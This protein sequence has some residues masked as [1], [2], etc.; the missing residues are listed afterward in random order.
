[1]SKLSKESHSSMKLAI[2]ILVLF[3]TSLNCYSQRDNYWDDGLH[4][5]TLDSAHL[6]FTASIQAAETPIGQ[7]IK[8]NLYISNDTTPRIL[9][10]EM[11]VT[12]RIYEARTII[13]GVNASMYAGGVDIEPLALSSNEFENLINRKARNKAIWGSIGSIA[14]GAYAATS[15]NLLDQSLGALTSA[16][17]ATSTSISVANDLKYRNFIYDE[18]IKR[19][20]IEPNRVAMGYMLFDISKTKNGEKLTGPNSKMGLKALIKDHNAKFILE[21]DLEG[22]IFRIPMMIDERMMTID[23]SRQ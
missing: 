13:E 9:F 3:I 20:S 22:S 18:Y 8:L 5:Y 10:D 12:A 15:D 21:I 19:T 7:L 11:K 16:S 6:H 17:I 14:A 1:M 2:T 4:Y 23:I